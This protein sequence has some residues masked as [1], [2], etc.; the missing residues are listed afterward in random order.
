MRG[1]PRRHG[2]DFPKIISVDDHVIEPPD[3]WQD[4]LPAEVPGRRAPHRAQ[5]RRRDDVRRRQVHLRA[6]RRRRARATGGSTRTCRSR[7]PASSAAVGFD[8]DEV[9]VTAITYEEMRQGCWDPKARLEDMDVNWTEAQMCFPSLP[10]LLRP[11]VH[12]RP[13]TRSSRRLCVKAYNDWMVE[14]WCGGSRRPPHPAEHHPALGR[15][16]GRRR[17]PPQRRPRRAR[18]LLQ[19]DPALPRAC[20][21]S[22]PATGIRSSRPATR[23][24]RSSTCTSGRRRRCRRPR[25]TRRRRSAR[26]S[27]S[28]TPWRRWPT[29]CSRACSCGFP[30]L[31]LAYSE[32]QIGWI[33][34]IL[35]RADK[36][37]E[38]NRAW[39]GVYGVD[40]RAAVAPTT[41][42]RSTA[43]SSTTSTGSR[44]PR[45]DRRR[46]HLLRDR[47][48]AL[49]QHLAPLQG[50]RPEADGPPARRR[51][52]QA[53]ARQ[54]HRDAAARPRPV[55]MTHDPDAEYRLLIGGEWVAAAGGTYDIVNPAT[56][57]VVG[58]A[59]NATVADAEAAA[60]AAADAFAALVAARSPRSAPR[61]SSGPPTSS[62]SGTPSWSRWCRPRPA[63]PCG[64]PSRS[65]C[66]WP[67]RGSAATRRASTRSSRSRS[68]RRS[69]RPRRSRRAASSAAWRAVRRSASWSCI[70]SYN[71]PLT[72]MAGKI[73]PA[74]AMG[75]TVVVK[76]APA[77]PARAS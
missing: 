11:D 65:R 33:P 63:P 57:Q 29:G 22:T 44:Q 19:R 28:A 41:T 56:E 68:R 37:W 3:V 59:P 45:E 13:T 21:R 6:G 76:P 35:E 74:L 23:P 62:T 17:G 61:C 46:Q 52:P 16:A 73:G 12:R 55:T 4:R 34:Y 26:R 32:G 8:R 54:R 70:T 5:P 14:E 27:P 42:A 18:R 58:D 75:N 31:K 60:A 40:P 66:R 30:T 77:G 15:R 39:G 2:D 67:R 69:C 43:A 1:Y 71:F 49:R 24:A 48:P 38:E 47:L 25:P 36:V 10:P 51:R 64:S 20:R 53:R 72:N 9:K 7:R 50:G